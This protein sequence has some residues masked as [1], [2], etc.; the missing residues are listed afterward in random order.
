MIVEYDDN[1]LNDEID[2]VM[3]DEV[4]ELIM[5]NEVSIEVVKSCGHKIT[6]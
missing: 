1:D 5:C 4:M 2:R 3:T 6:R